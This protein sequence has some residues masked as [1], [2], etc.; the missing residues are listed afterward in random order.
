[1]AV[2]V[3]YG[4]SGGGLGFPVREWWCKDER[5][6]GR[7]V[8]WRLTSKNLSAN[9]THA[10]I[11]PCEV[12]RTSWAVSGAAIDSV[13]ELALSMLLFNGEMVMCVTEDVWKLRF[14]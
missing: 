5:E 13:R 7:R 1:M 2:R 6:A 14:K 11:L 8:W 3:E 4:M 12:I 10:F 9:S